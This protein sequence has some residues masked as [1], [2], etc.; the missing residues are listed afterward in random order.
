MIKAVKPIEQQKIMLSKAITNADYELNTSEIAI[1]LGILG[2]IPQSKPIEV[3]SWHHLT[4]EEYA[5]IRKVTKQTARS[6]LKEASDKLWQRTLYIWNDE[7]QEKV[8][9]RWIVTRRPLNKDGIFSIQWH[10]DIIP[11]LCELK[12]YCT[13]SLARVRDIKH[14]MTYRLYFVLLEHSYKKQSGVIEF[15]LADFRDKLQ[16]DGCYGEYRYLKSK[17]L[18]PALEELENKEL[19]RVVLEEVRHSRKVTGFRLKY[20][21]GDR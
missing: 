9:Y 16:L 10:P 7:L 17:L 20:L 4:V 18:K 3:G 19:A 21:L 11:F 1:F 14:S 2:K 12:K 8:E 13:V 5:A 15:D 6:M